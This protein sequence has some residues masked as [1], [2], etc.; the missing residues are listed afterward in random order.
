MSEITYSELMTE[1]DK[2]TDKCDIT[3]EQIE[4]LKKAKSKNISWDE[5]LRMWNSVSG[6]K[7]YKTYQ[8]L[9]KLYK[10]NLK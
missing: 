3:P 10:D 2:Y 4:F 7:K 6:W 9:Y 1:L 8:S 5:M